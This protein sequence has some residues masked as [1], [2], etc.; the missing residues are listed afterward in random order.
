[1]RAVGIEVPTARSFQSRSPEI[2]GAKMRNLY[3]T[4][5]AV[6]LALALMGAPAGAVPG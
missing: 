5:G 2:H 4:T 3:L 1:M 6:A